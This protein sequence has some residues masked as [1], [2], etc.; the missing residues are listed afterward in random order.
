MT[1]RQTANRVQHAKVLLSA[2]ACRPDRGS[3]PG[4]GWNIAQELVRHCAQVWVVT[5]AEN[6]P[7]ITEALQQTPVPRLHFV[8]HDLPDWAVW[9]RQVRLHYYLWQTSV[10]FMARTLHQEVGFDLVQHVTYGRYCV[11]SSLAF[12][13]VPFIWGPVGGAEAAPRAFREDFGLA[14]KLFEMLRDLSCW[15]GERDPLVRLTAARSALALA[16]TDETA[17]RLQALKVRRVATTLSSNGIHT[18]ELAQFQQLTA[19]AQNRPVR[20]ISTGR[21][22]HWKGFHLGL[23]AFA[24][25][26][27]PAGEF[28][29]VGDGPERKRLEALAAALG[30]A[31]QVKFL[32]A[33]TREQ[34]LAALGACDVLVH[35][36]LHDF[37]PAVC[38]EAMAAGRPVICLDIGGA[39]NQITPETGI[40][41]AAQTP[42]Q[43]VQDMVA[44]M[45]RLERDP[46]LRRR[47]GQAGQQ[48]VQEFFRWENKGRDLVCFYQEVLSAA[49]ANSLGGE[50]DRRKRLPH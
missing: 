19:P 49:G 46:G 20:F 12:L 10:Y 48:R 26:Q 43:T 39:A 36:S 24:Q 33:L 4:V 18:H 14:G 17:A 34:A 40:K 27:L 44:A 41:V 50:A 23:R 9:R 31:K 11:P 5:R 30:I 21:L 15:I 1:T 7:M 2:Y 29:M 37:S 16:V 6:R 22:L 8:Y 42:E 32:G 3:E 47:M 35:P 45:V 25:A 38:L 28:W 13:P